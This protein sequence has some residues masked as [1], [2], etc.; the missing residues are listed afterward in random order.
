MLS[1]VLDNLVADELVGFSWVWS[2]RPGSM[3][4][5]LR[6]QWTYVCG[7]RR[8]KTGYNTRRQFPVSLG[9]ALA[10]DFSGSGWI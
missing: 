5:R 10:N 1:A 7:D 3:D 4:Y 6:A 9:A 8:F 2:T